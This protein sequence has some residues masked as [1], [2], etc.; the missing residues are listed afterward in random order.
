MRKLLHYFGWHW[1]RYYI[2]YENIAFLAVSCRVCRIC[3]KMEQYK[4]TRPYEQEG[5]YG[6]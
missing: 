4:V 5:H 1:W 3:D 2:D 6:D